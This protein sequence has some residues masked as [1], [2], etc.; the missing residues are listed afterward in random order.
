MQLTPCPESN[1]PSQ[2]GRCTVAD[3]RQSGGTIVT[4]ELPDDYA[5]LLAKRVKFGDWRDKRPTMHITPPAST[6][7]EMTICR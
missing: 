3:H 1:R 5:A 6:I 4:V 2:T 7:G